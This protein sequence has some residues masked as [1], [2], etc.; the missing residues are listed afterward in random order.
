MYSIKHTSHVGWTWIEAYHSIVFMQMKLM[1]RS[2][3][4][5]GF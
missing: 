3:I 4:S 1:C 2:W 5:I